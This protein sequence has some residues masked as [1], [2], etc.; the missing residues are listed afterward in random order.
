MFGKGY[1]RSK[2]RRYPL[3]I[4]GRRRERVRAFGRAREDLRCLSGQ[5]NLFV[6][7]VWLREG[8]IWIRV[9]LLHVEPAVGFI[10][11]IQKRIQLPGGSKLVIAHRLLVASDSGTPLHAN[12]V[13]LRVSGSGLGARRA[14]HGA[15][16][17]G[18]PG[19]HDGVERRLD[20][21][22]GKG[23]R[24]NIFGVFVPLDVTESGGE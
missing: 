11:P 13:G 9:D 16:G 22:F 7:G 5:I 10:A 3:A 24:V 8:T 19:L 1:R 12:L 21:V 4:W 15:V 23:D 20:R 2:F 6:V 18:R 17:L 14:C